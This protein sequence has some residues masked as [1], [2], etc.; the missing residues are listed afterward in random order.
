[1][2]ATTHHID[3]KT[4]Y[5]QGQQ[6]NIGLQQIVEQLQ[7]ELMQLKKLIFEAAMNAS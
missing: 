4:L 6:V 2:Q 1:M 3:Y 7:L 5:E